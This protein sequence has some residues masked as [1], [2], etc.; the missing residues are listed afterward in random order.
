LEPFAPSNTS[1]TNYNGRPR[2]TWQRQVDDDYITNFNIYRSF[3]NHNFG[4]SK[5]A[6]IT[7]QYYVDY[8]V[9]VGYG[10]TA[11]YKVKAVNGTKES[12]FSNYASINYYGLNKPFFNDSNG[13]ELVNNKYRLYSNYPNPFNPSTTIKYSISSPGNVKL[14]VYNLRGEEVTTLVNEFKKAGDYIVEFKAFNYL[15]SSTYIYRISTKEYSEFKKMML[16]K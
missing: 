10:N 14:Q 7:N 13:V 6:S 3:F 12:D 9:L 16:L 2:I 5:I 11:Y 4:Y 1:A 8:D 15:P